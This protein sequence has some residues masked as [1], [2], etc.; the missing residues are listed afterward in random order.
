[1][2]IV[3][4]IFRPISE[5]L[6]VDEATKVKVGF[7]THSEVVNLS[8]FPITCKIVNLIVRL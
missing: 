4:F 1:M 3:W 6:F 8:S 7:V 2:E 5:G